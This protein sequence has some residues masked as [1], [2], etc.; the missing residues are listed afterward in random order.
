[1]I[2]SNGNEET[3]ASDHQ[4]EQALQIQI[5]QK[6]EVGRDNEEKSQNRKDQASQNEKIQELESKNDQLASQVDHLLKSLQDLQGPWQR[7][8]WEAQDCQTQIPT[9]HQSYLP[10]QDIQ[11]NMAQTVVKNHRIHHIY[12]N[13]Q[14]QLSGG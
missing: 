14:V 5:Q 3:R 2:G 9:F 12:T 6:Q 11:S 10:N 7:R 13:E 4:Q 8:E 1:M